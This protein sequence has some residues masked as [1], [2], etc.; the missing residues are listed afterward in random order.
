M[1]GEKIKLLPR[2]WLSRWAVLSKPSCQI[3]CK[4]CSSPVDKILKKRVA[5]LIA[6]RRLGTICTISPPPPPPPQNQHAPALHQWEQTYCGTPTGWLRDTLDLPLKPQK[7]SFPPAGGGS[8]QLGRQAC[9]GAWKVGGREDVDCGFA[10]VCVPAQVP[11][12]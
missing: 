11:C 6:K 12:S 9:R 2:C 8:R 1:M 4:R 7:H 10:W 3:L 5:T